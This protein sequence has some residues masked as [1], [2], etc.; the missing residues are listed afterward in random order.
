MSQKTTDPVASPIAATAR[1]GRK[2]TSHMKATNP[3]PKSRPSSRLSRARSSRHLVA[4]VAPEVLARAF[5]HQV[6]ERAL[7]APGGGFPLQLFGKRPDPELVAP[8]AGQPAAEGEE[9]AHPFALGKPGGEGHGV[10]GA[11]EELSTAARRAAG[12][13]A[14][15]GRRG[16]SA[17]LRAR[18]AGRRGS[19]CT[20]GGRRPRPS[21]PRLR[22]APGRG[23]R[24]PPRR[25][26]AP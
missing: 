19:W 3:R 14:C 17:P 15:S 1:K 25:R 7:Q 23:G 11:A 24:R 13:A 18:Q 12:G 21:R 2:R 22:R 8:P 20:R 5:A 9:A 4:V 16:S 6:L 26:A 10:R